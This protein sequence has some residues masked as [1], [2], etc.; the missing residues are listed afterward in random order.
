MTALKKRL[1]LTLRHR[2]VLTITLANALL[3]SIMVWQAFS[4]YHKS[5][6]REVS[7]KHTALINGYVNTCAKFILEEDWGGLSETTTAL[8]NHPG[9]ISATVTDSNGKVIFSSDAKMVGKTLE[10]I[11]I[12]KAA[13]EE[14]QDVITPISVNEHNVGTLWVRFSIKD[15]V[16]GKKRAKNIAFG[17]SILLISLN[18]AV[19]F[20]LGKTF[21]KPIEKLASISR[22]ISRGDYSTHI[23]V[24]TE[25]EVGDLQKALI[26]MI[27]SLKMKE[28]DIRKE[29]ER[30]SIVCELGKTINSKLN[31]DDVYYTFAQ[32]VKKLVPYDRIS[33]SSCDEKTGTIHMVAVLQNNGSASAEKIIRPK[34][35]S[36]IGWAIDKKKPFIRKDTALEKQFYEDKIEGIRSYIIVPLISKGKA[37]GTFNLGSHIPNSYDATV[38]E[39]LLPLSQQVTIAMENSMLFSELQNLFINTITT[40][41]EAIDA[42]SG[43]T[44]GH[45]DRVMALSIAIGAKMGLNKSALDRLKL[46]AL[47]HDIGKIG[48]DRELLYKSGALMGSEYDEFKKHPSKGEEIL[49]HI[50]QLQDIMPDIRHHHE[51]YDGKG[52]PDGLSRDAIPIGARILAAAD[53]FDAMTTDR[54]YRSAKSLAEA[55]DELIKCSGTQFEP[56]VVKALIEVLESDIS[57][58]I[59]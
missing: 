29:A 45:S 4:I 32:G 59:G 48:T 6:S 19:V 13:S 58:G 53:A 24:T 20:I 43:W 25:D 7:A 40:L 38:L 50:K 28:E 30:T 16:D 33:I 47:L 14:N 35:R 57:K 5:L 55:K 52:Y 15:I 12:K 39:I 37:I 21:A 17:I 2:L 1:G 56:D 8:K 11:K 46:A 36:A 3:L 54:P 27:Q 44:R 22:R 41:T 18:A 26:H 42:K 10:E 23:R 9:V 51:R 34:E 31:I 49:R